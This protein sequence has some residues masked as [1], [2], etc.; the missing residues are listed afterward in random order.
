MAPLGNGMKNDEQR[1]KNGQAVRSN[2]REGAYFVSAEVYGPGVPDATIGT[3]ATKSP[4][5]AG[6]IWTVDEVS[7]KYSD[8]RD[9]T[10]VAE[11][12]PDDHGVAE[13]RACVDAA[14]ETG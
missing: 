7:R 8:L 6:A 12:S 5:G 11:L 2:D 1:L 9:G 13:S 14:R 10:K 3:W 4:G